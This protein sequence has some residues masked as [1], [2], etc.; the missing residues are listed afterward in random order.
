V[1]EN[2]ESRS[3]LS[4]GSFLPAL[5]GIKNAVKKKEYMPVYL[6]IIMALRNP[7]A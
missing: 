2:S 7:A 3:Q 5:F 4:S 6:A 1:V